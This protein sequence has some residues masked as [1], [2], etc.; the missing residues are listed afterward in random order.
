Q[1]IGAWNGTSPETALNWQTLQLSFNGAGRTQ[2]L[3]IVS[4]ATRFDANGRGVMID[5]IALTETLPPNSGFEDSAIRL[6]AIT[7]GLT[8]TDGSETLT[9]TLEAL[10]VGA[11]LSDGRHSFTA[12]QGK[13]SADITGWNTAQLSLTPPKD[14]TGSLTLNVVATATEKANGQQLRSTAELKLTVLPVN[15]APCAQSV[16][17]AVKAGGSVAIDLARL[18]G[19]VDSE[20]L[21]FTL[22]APKYGTLQ[23]MANGAFTYT[24]KVGFVGIDRFS[25]T[26]FDG[27][28][29]T[30]ATITLIVSRSDHGASLVLQSSLTSEPI[31]PQAGG[32][33]VANQATGATA[34]ATPMTTT[35]TPTIAIDWQGRA[36]HADQAVET[37]WVQ[38]FFAKEKVP[39]SLAELTGLVVRLKK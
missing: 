32:F 13:T 12:T 24:P 21:S 22:G 1:K 36:P 8:D 29:S 35:T 28:A 18:F 33:V 30:T 9:L 19:D 39:K 16:C 2:T 11:V 34:T 14:Y 4:E 20:G 27:Q 10:P 17:Y 5:D 25:Y 31:P 7:A 3:K 6:S 38:E 23:K 26:V 15:D 37:G